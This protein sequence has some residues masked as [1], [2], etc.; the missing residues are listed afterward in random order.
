[1]EPH[2]EFQRV[3]AAQFLIGDNV[4]AEIVAWAPIFFGRGGRSNPPQRQRAAAYG[5]GLRPLQVRPCSGSVI[6]IAKHGV[7]LHAPGR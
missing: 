1:M 7:A 5:R 4:E 3:D 2:G 6:T